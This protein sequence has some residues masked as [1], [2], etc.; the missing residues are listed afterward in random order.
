MKEITKF[1]PEVNRVWLDMDGVLADFDKK[2]IEMFNGIDPEVFD[3]TYGQDEFWRI[4]NSNPNFFRELE[5]ME[6][7]FELYNA[8]KNFK[9]GIITGIPKDMDAGSNQK[10]EWAKQHFP[11]IDTVICCR[12][13]HKNEYCIPGDILIDDRSVYIK[14]WVSVGGYYILHKTAKKSIWQLR[15]WINS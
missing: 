7:A 3:I 4:L 1:N 13:R 10:L 9:H 8:V 2:A 12:A 5:P 11:L 14:Q 15:T 6:D